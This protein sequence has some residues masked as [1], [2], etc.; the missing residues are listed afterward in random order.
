MKKALEDKIE[1]LQSENLK[2]EQKLNGIQKIKDRIQANT[3]IIEVLAG[4]LE[5]SP[6]EASFKPEEKVP[7]LKVIIMKY[8]RSHLNEIIDSDAVEKYLARVRGHPTGKG[9]LSTYLGRL[10]R[11]GSLERIGQKRFRYVIPKEV[12]SGENPTGNKIDTET[13]I[14]E[15]LRS[16]AHEAM[17]VAKIQEEIKKKYPT[18][19][20]KGDAIWFHLNKKLIPAGLVKKVALGTYQYEITGKAYREVDSFAVSE[21]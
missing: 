12:L 9:T 20:I 15:V 18:R 1:S 11:D 10:V 3:R 14:L 5:G 4:L 19:H 2:L 17:K 13:I 16:H 7:S 21:D 8:A 6:E